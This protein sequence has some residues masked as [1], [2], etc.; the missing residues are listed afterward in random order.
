MNAR[1]ARVVLPAAAGVALLAG[2]AV[3]VTGASALTITPFHHT[4]TYT[5]N[6]ATLPPSLTCIKY[7]D[8]F[9]LVMHD[10]IE[11]YQTVQRGEKGAKEATAFG[12][13]GAYTHILG[14]DLIAE[15]I[16]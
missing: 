11:R 16:Y 8:G 3:N 9:V 7:S 5:G 14:T 15:V 4:P 12:K 13:L 10:T 1:L 2:V 6:C